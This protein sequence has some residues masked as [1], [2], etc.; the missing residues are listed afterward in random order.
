MSVSEFYY[1]VALKDFMIVMN[2]NCLSGFKC[3]LIDFQ[4]NFNR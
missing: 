3:N 2:L 1:R 4:S